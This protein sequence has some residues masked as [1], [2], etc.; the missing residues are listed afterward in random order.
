MN[1]HMTRC[2]NELSFFRIGFTRKV[3]P[4]S[5]VWTKLLLVLTLMIPVCAQDAF[6]LSTHYILSFDRAVP[7]YK[8]CYL[9]NS[10]LSKLSAALVNDGANPEKDFLS[11]V[12]YSFD[13]DHPSIQKYVVPYTMDDGSHLIWNKVNTFDL[14]R[15]LKSGEKG[16]PHL[17]GKIASAQL[18]SKQFSV[19]QTM[20]DSADSTRF[21][22][23]TILLVIT[24]ELTNG[25]KDYRKEWKDISE[26]GNYAVFSQIKNLVFNKLN[27]FDE[28]FRIVNIEF[29]GISSD[30]VTVALGGLYPYKI[31][32]YEVVPT[33]KPSIHSVTDFPSPLPLKRV[34][35]GYKVDI[36]SSSLYDKYSI[37][38]ISIF[39]AEGKVLN[40]NEG[41]KLAFVIPLDEIS[42][43]D[44]LTTSMTLRLN[45]GLY[46]GAL[47]SGKNRKY[48]DGMTAMQ[49]VRVQDDAKVLGLFPLW[50]FFWWWSPEDIFT[51]V[52]LWDLIIALILIIGLTLTVMCLIKRFAAYEPSSEIIT[53]HPIVK[54]K[55]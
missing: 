39:N 9:S 53:I 45:D 22:D 14:P 32:A 37:S 1:H 46:N 12:G 10:V 5:A 17:S 35:G 15:I 19:M 40:K 26:T 47:I 54:H 6:G 51:A 3:N 13:M 41:G 49:I 23:R 36:Y 55:E 7:I 8:D 31:I 38:D 28:Q 48:S 27:R 20:V 43:G 16:L 18:F 34:R 42:P 44:T 52:M 21:A 4:S 24:D 33:E 30:G 29:G 11:V 50:D 2:A 25:S